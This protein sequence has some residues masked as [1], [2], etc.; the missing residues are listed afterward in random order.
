MNALAP[1][2]RL[3]VAGRLCATPAQMHAVEDLA[4][5]ALGGLT[6]SLGRLENCTVGG[7]KAYFSQIVANKVADYLRRRPTGGQ[8][9]RQGRLP[10]LDRQRPVQLGP[11]LA[12]SVR[13]GHV[14]DQRR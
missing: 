14:A 12:T 3:M 8:R 9:P 2:A 5:N 4:Q 1:Q 6:E 7:L 13:L 10:R 11:A